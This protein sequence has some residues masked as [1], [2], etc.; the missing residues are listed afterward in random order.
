MKHDD[1]KQKVINFD[2][3]G[4]VQN[5]ILIPNSVI[6]IGETFSVDGASTLITMSV[7]GPARYAILIV[8][9]LQDNDRIRSGRQGGGVSR[10]TIGNGSK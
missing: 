10:C 3:N 4:T 7:S 6:T 5:I 2:G 1:A 8:A 9:E